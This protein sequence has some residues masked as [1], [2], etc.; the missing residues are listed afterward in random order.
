MLKLGFQ[1][2]L[3]LAF[4]NLIP[5]PPLDGS[6]IAQHLSPTVVGRFYAAIR[7][8]GF[9]IFLGLVFILMRSLFPDTGGLSFF[10]VLLGLGFIVVSAYDY[11]FDRLHVPPKEEE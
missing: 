10:F 11:L 8:Y 1:V 3:M 4:F 2:N 9:L 7:P 6:W 5:I